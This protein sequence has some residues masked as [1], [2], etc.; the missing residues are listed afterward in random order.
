MDSKSYLDFDEAVVLLKTTP[1]TL[2]KWLQNGKVPGHKLGRQW[3]FLRDELE[4]FMHAPSVQT[5]THKE[6]ELLLRAI[7]IEHQAMCPIEIFKAL[8]WHGLDG[9][10]SALQFQPRCNDYEIIYR[11][12]NTRHSIAHISRGFF[13]GLCAAML[14]GFEDG[15]EENAR[16]IALNRD[17]QSLH[18]RLQVVDTVMGA[19]VSC[20]IFPELMGQSTLD[21]IALS[22]E[23]Y[24]R[25]RNWIER[26]NG[27]IIVTGALGSGKTTTIYALLQQAVAL[28]RSVFTL[29]DGADYPLEDVN[30]VELGQ[31]SLPVFERQSAQILNAD[32]EVMAFIVNSFPGLEPT[33]YAQAA[34]A[35]NCGRLVILQTTS[36]SIEGAL[37]TAQRYLLPE[38]AGTFVGVIEQKLMPQGKGFKAAYRFAEL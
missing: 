34:H 12:Q 10:Y 2:Y 33:L 32:A 37:A 24:A 22:P 6:T 8:L 13:N 16:R 5:D 7:G 20:I 25:L 38:Y 15:G 3:R 11:S 30:H 23:E 18:G 26:K 28:G 4:G 27:I 1:S 31:R 14:Q 17:G 29:E 36:V 35:S 9:K 19:H 21:D